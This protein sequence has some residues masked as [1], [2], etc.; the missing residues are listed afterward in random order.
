MTNAERSAPAAPAGTAG[1]KR[2]WLILACV[3]AG[4]GLLVSLAAVVDT[5]VT[6][7]AFSLWQPSEFTISRWLSSELFDLVRAR[8]P[9]RLLRIEGY[10]QALAILSWPAWGCLGLLTSWLVRRNCPRDSRASRALGWTLLALACCL[11]AA[12]ISSY[13]SWQCI[14]V[15]PKEV[16]ETR[17]A[18]QAER[19]GREPTPD[20]EVHASELGTRYDEWRR[21][22][23]FRLFMRYVPERQTGVSP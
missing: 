22:S 19:E 6:W 17:L 23:I 18:R 5:V 11:P 12:A 14:F 20:E 16:F 7:R 2:R 9:K 1:P 21:E 4:L 3:L 8:M 15:S 10:L 13:I